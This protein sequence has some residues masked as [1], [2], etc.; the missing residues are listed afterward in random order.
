MQVAVQPR[1]L[2]VDRCVERVFVNA[3]DVVVE[4][5][6]A[7]L[8]AADPLHHLLGAFSQRHAAIGIYG[9]IG[10]RGPMQGA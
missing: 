5:R 2:D 7:F 9:R 3:D 4:E 10:R 8:E 1:R 6:A